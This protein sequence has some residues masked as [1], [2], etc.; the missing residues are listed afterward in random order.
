[1]VNVTGA[2]LGYLLGGELSMLM[3]MPRPDQ[4]T[5]IGSNVMGLLLSSVW[6]VIV[7]WVISGNIARES[8]TRSRWR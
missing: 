1:M 2:L 7:L 5:L 3:G 8:L 4:G 6:P